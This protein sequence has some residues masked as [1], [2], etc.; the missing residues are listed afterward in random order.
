MKRRILAFWMSVVLI[1]AQAVP[2]FAGDLEMSVFSEEMTGNLDEI[3]DEAVAAGENAESPD[4]DELWIGQEA[5]TE[6]GSAA[7]I[8]DAFDGQG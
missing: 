7:V 1:L 6:E 4:S 8:S 5:E 2:A 3:V